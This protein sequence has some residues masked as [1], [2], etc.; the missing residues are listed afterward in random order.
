MA[1]TGRR[2]REMKP[3][4]LGMGPRTV[5]ARPYGEELV[6]LVVRPSRHASSIFELTIWD[7]E[8]A[9]LWIDWLDAF[10]RAAEYGYAI[11][12]PPFPVSSHLAEYGLACKY[13]WEL[14]A[15]QEVEAQQREA[16]R[17]R[18]KQ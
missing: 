9:D 10:C 3:R 4:L 17:R 14:S 18:E 15:L 11:P 16:A 7:L 1:R 13:L 6:R 2:S 8:F 5:E 12:R